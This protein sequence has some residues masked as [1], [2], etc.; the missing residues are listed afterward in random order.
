MLHIDGLVEDCSISSALAVEILQSCTK[1]SI[2]SSV[3]MVLS[4]SGNGFTLN[5][6]AITGTNDNCQL[7]P[8]E[9]TTM[10]FE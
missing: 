2:Y 10:K 8:W 9:H 4:G 3:N 5:R 1:P 7:I 6:Q